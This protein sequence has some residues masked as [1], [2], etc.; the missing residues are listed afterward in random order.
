MPQ[1]PYLLW[2]WQKLK[3]FSQCLWSI[4]FALSSMDIFH[5]GRRR[6]W[7]GKNQI[8]FHSCWRAWETQARGNE[9]KSPPPSP[10]S[11]P[12][13]SCRWFCVSDHNSPLPGRAGDPDIPEVPSTENHPRA[14]QRGWKCQQLPGICF[15]RRKA[16]RSTSW[17]RSP[18]S[19]KL[20]R[21]NL[22]TLWLTCPSSTNGATPQVHL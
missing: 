8:P 4:V 17:S 10:P 1:I 9:N 11:P 20:A 7:K 18:L 19:S 21:L 16:A 14:S 5:D 13:L 22:T 6:P 2:L 3:K 12:S 15:G